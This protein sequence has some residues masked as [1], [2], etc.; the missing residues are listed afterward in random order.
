MLGAFGGMNYAIDKLA[1]FV[2]RQVVW[3]FGRGS[4]VFRLTILLPINRLHRS[5]NLSKLCNNN[6]SVF[7]CVQDVEKD[8][9][10]SGFG[11]KS[12]GIARLPV[13]VEKVAMYVAIA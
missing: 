8:L 5:M 9:A 6:R 10:Q 4:C 7:M 2:K 3:C 13:G 11:I 1:F 12:K